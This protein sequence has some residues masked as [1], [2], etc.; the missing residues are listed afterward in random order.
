MNFKLLIFSTFLAQIFA[1]DS[2]MCPCPCKPAGIK[3]KNLIDCFATWSP[4]AS[5]DDNSN[6]KGCKESDVIYCRTTENNGQ[7]C[8]FDGTNNLVDTPDEPKC[9]YSCGVHTCNSFLVAHNVHQSECILEL[10]K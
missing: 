9:W 2:C 4:N 8:K 5:T 6:L 1:Q 3:L 10:F 7:F